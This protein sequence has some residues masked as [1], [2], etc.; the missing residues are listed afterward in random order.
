MKRLTRLDPSEQ[1][2]HRFPYITD[3]VNDVFAKEKT[4]W[5]F[6]LL[7]PLLLVF[8]FFLRF[9]SFPLKFF[10]RRVPFGFEAFMIDSCMAFGMK[11]LARHDAAELFI[12]HVQI[13]PLLYRHILACRNAPAENAGTKLNGIDGEFGVEDI[14]TIVRNNLTIGHDLLSYELVDR[15]DKRVF[16]DNLEYIRSIKPGDHDEYSKAVLEIN[17][18]HSFQILG[19]TNLVLLIVTAINCRHGLE[20]I[21]LRL[22]FVMVHETDLR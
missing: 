1:E 14:K 3:Y 21:W 2:M 8:Y 22:D 16:L 12:R 18:K 11:Y 17:R 13:E 7:R 6:I 9:V 10:L 5:D 20:F 4:Q 15:F 19:P